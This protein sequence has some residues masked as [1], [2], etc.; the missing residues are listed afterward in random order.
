MIVYGVMQLFNHNCVTIKSTVSG[1]NILLLK[2]ISICDQ[3][4]IYTVLVQTSFKISKDIS[5]I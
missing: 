1:K 3:I 4:S 2:Q 5:T